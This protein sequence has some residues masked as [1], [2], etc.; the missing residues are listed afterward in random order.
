MKYLAILLSAVIFL[1]FCEPPKQ[2]RLE[3]TPTPELSPTPA[4]MAESSCDSAFFDPYPDIA[5][6]MNWFNEPSRVRGS[7]YIRS[8]VDM[9][10][11][12]YTTDAEY[13]LKGMVDIDE[14]MH[15]R[16]IEVYGEKDAADLGIFYVHQYEFLPF[17]VIQ[18]TLRVDEFICREACVDFLLIDIEQSGETYTFDL[19][20]FPHIYPN[21]WDLVGS[22]VKLAADIY[23]G[24]NIWDYNRLIPRY[25]C[26]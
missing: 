22:E 16:V 20:S 12:L 25:L 15:R 19:S 9:D 1:S 10:P 3:D 5:E 6:R 4:F 18:G 11:V 21:L 2:P 13:A 23:P 8:G 24:E 26:R 17:A 14:E 7:F